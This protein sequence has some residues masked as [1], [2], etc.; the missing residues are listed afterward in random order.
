MNGSKRQLMGIDIMSIKGYIKHEICRLLGPD[1]SS[2]VPIILYSAP[3]HGLEYHFNPQIEMS[4]IESKRDQVNNGGEFET[5]G[6]IQL[7]TA[8]GSLLKDKK[9][10][11]NIGCGI[12]TFENIHAPNNPGVQYLACDYDPASID[13]CIDN[14]AYDNVEYRTC[15]MSDILLEKR[16]FDVALA[17]DVIEH[18]ENYKG[19][20]DEF[21]QLSNQA[22]ITTPN[23]E[24]YSTWESLLRPQYPFHVQEF[25]PG[26]LFFILKMYY[27]DVA[28]FTLNYS[29]TEL[30]KIG[31]YTRLPQLIAYCRK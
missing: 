15:T 5:T 24:R 3:D 4:N 21:S 26:E 19:F 8:I 1:Y 27:E 22:I 25:N 23:R 6:M 7:N 28:L 9:T 20:L 12:G 30:E 14:R 29:T 10:V 13:W 16:T 31:L 18:L 11:V 17:V 2:K